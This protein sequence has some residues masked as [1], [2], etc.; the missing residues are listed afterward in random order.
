VKFLA[1]LALAA[2]AYLAFEGCS[3][4]PVN[5]V[6]TSQTASCAGNPSLCLSGTVTLDPRFS[7][8]PASVQVALYGLFPA[9]SVP[10]AARQ[11]V[12]PDGTWAFSAANGADAG[13]GLPAWSHYFV[14][15]AVSFSADAGSSVPNAIAGPLTVPSSG[16]PI[17]IRITPLQLELLESRGVGGTYLVNSVLAF[18]F[19][20]A[21]GEEVSGAT[22]SLAVGGSSTTIPWTSLP[23]D[24]G[25]AYYATFSPAPPAQP[26]YTITTTYPAG[27]APVTYELVANPPAFDG[28]VMAAPVGTSAGAPVQVSWSPEPQA[29]YELVEVFASQD[30]GYAATPSYA[31]SS[32]DSPDA[33]AETIEAGV[34]GS[35]PYLVNVAYAK[36]NCPGDA[37][38]CVIA[39]SVAAQ[40]VTVP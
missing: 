10:V 28:T 18:V 26:T 21:T 13:A 38:G 25:S 36:A 33:T 1:V 16:E 30:G 5:S 6:V 15:A 8:Q 3:T 12:G 14:R 40:T 20:P 2:L 34:L 29:D 27:A 37:A 31:S 22:V 17:A 24:A 35:G 39:Q 4:N 9:G 19:D 32:P 7:T 23:G 11:R